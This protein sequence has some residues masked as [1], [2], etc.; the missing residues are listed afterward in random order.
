MM[1]SDI[2]RCPIPEKRNI[3]IFLVA[4]PATWGLL[5]LGSHGSLGWA[6]LAAWAFALVNHT[7]FSLLHEAVHGVFSR[8]R[9][10]NDLFGTLSATAFPTSFTLQK[11]AHLGH[12]R[13]NR[14]DEELYDYYLPNQSKALRNFHLYAGNLLG[15]YWFCIPASNL[16]YLLAPWLY[17]SRWFVEGPARYLGFEPYVREIGQHSPGRIW[18]ECLLAFSYQALLWWV[19]DLTWQGW[20]L[21]HWAFALHWSA[22]QYVDHAWSPRDV[23]RGAWNL[24]V[25]PV[26]R[27]LALNYHYHLAHHRHP[28]VPW[29]YLPRLVDP[30][31]PQPT[32]WRIY[33][34]LWRGT[35]PA[36]PMGAP[37]SLDPV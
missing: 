26:T 21:C 15:F 19:L 6:L 29:V 10:R 36:P 37:A 11:I 8:N 13:R 23:A 1:R 27:A 30:K 34:S 24:K 18:A 3:A 31:E 28:A 25:L 7:P 22:L 4:L 14:T 9:A 33:F 20:L 16:I 17:A 35:R 12:H 5:W 32:F 2:E